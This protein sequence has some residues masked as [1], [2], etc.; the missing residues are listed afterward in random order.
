MTD[1][2]TFFDFKQKPTKEDVETQSIFLDGINEHQSYQDAEKA[3]KAVMYGIIRVTEEKFG[4]ADDK[5]YADCAV[6]SVLIMGMFLRQRGIDTA[7]T[8]LLDSIREGI[9]GIQSVEKDESK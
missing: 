2:V 5:F 7:E 3:A 9:Q 6:I 1:N 4:V 8:D